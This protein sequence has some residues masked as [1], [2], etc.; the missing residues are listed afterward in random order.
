VGKKDE[1][2]DLVDDILDNVGE[3]RER[4]S[5]F[6]DRLLS[7][8]SDQ[9]AV[10]AEYVAK[11]AAELSRQ[12]QVRVNTVKAFGKVLEVLSDDDEDDITDEIGRPFPEEDFDEG[13][14]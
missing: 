13:S 9:P 4:L 10:I 1:L 6:L 3:D 2:A 5:N 11:I 14:N 7:E 8:H 12:N